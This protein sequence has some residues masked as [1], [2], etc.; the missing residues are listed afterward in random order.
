MLFSQLTHTHSAM[1]PCHKVWTISITISIII[2]TR[3]SSNFGTISTKS[4]KQQKRVVQRSQPLSPSTIISRLVPSYQLKKAKNKKNEKNYQ[5]FE[6]NCKERLTSLSGL[7]FTK[8]LT[9]NAFPENR[10]EFANF[11]TTVQMRVAVVPRGLV[12][13][14]QNSNPAGSKYSAFSPISFFC[15][16]SWPE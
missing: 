9:M 11:A 8:M 1:N 7:V 15:Q 16:I 4:V 13:N 12:E 2:M 6:G 14:I 5:N 10:R 3:A